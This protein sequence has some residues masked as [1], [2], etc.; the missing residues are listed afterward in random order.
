M[1]CY[2][3]APEMSKKFVEMGYYLGVGGLLRDIK[4]WKKLLGLLL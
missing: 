4:V 2:S 1:H 3:G